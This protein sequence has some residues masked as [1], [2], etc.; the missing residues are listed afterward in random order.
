MKKHVFV[1]GSLRTNGQ[2]DINTWSPAPVFIGSA[3][4]NAQLYKIDLYPGISVG[5][6][7]KVIGEVYQ[8]TSKLEKILDKIEGI[9]V[10][11]DYMKSTVTALVNGT[12]IECLVYEMNGKH[13]IIDNLIETGDWFN[14]SKKVKRLKS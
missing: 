7:K 2:F 11:D 12:Q 6:D 1:Y 14:Q 9:G 4:I 3:T 10:H 13:K 8:I 5:G